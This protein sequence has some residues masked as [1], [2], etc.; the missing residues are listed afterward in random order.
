MT[1]TLRLIIMDPMPEG[2]DKVCETLAVQLH[3]KHAVK[4]VRS[5]GDY[6]CIPVCKTVMCL[7]VVIIKWHGACMVVCS[8]TVHVCVAR[9]R[10]SSRFMHVHVWRITL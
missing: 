5:V 2:D 9:G 6:C 1:L 3:N 8:Y 4:S 7:V 10:G